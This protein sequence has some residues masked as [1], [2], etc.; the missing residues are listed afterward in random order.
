MNAFHGLGMGGASTLQAV[1][2]GISEALVA[3]AVGLAAAIPA[4]VAYNYFAVAVRQFRE[5]MHHFTE[6]FMTFTRDGLAS[7]G[8]G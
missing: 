3:T 7:N 5:S 4:A 2:P 6:D 8:E 1:A